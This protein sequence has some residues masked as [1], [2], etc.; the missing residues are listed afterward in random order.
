MTSRRRFATRL[1]WRTAALFAAVVL[2]ALLAVWGRAPVAALLAGLAAVAALVSLWQ[3]VDQGNADLA[4]FV[5]A[6]ARGDLTQSFLRP[7]RGSHFDRV[8]I[9]YERALARLRDERAASA[10]STRFAESL[11]DGAPVALLVLG[12]DDRVTLANQA[13]RRLFRRSGDVPL[14]ALA[15]SGPAFLA[16]LAAV[17]PGSSR[18][19]VLAGGG[20]P[21][22]V[23]LDA[24]LM[25][26]GGIRRRIVAVRVVQPELDRAELDAQV[27]LVRVLT[28]EIM[29]SLT[30]VVS[31][32]ATA[33]RLIA[34]VA[35]D[36]APGI[37]DARLA[38]AAL[39]RRAAELEQFVE[40]YKGFSEAPTLV[41]T[42]IVVD[43]WLGRVIH[44]FRATPHGETARVDIS[45]AP[46]MPA[47]DGDAALLTQVFLNL[48]KNAAEAAPAGD[49]VAIRV[50]AALG[51]DGEITLSVSDGGPGVPAHLRHDV[52][53]PFFTTKRTGT[54]IGLSFARQV[55]L[56][57]GG[58]I[59]IGEQ[60]PS[61]IEIR[62]PPHARDRGA[63]LI[64]KMA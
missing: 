54:G 64:D 10:A 12:E 60:Q 11:A 57:H 55:I 24:T 39:A 25:E 51:S 56:L 37:A 35:P 7:R 26:A 36:L 13:A 58:Q 20:M 40:S 18:L 48:L 53:L 43:E 9:A 29:N 59:G 30:P 17:A 32:A 15:P 38:V 5:G 6:L 34:G 46:E 23:S 47:I 49:G 44:L 41:R 61:R 22:R 42:P 31:L 4:R 62:L 27:D 19:S 28:H 2:T 14:A 63:G 1:V 50:T 33:D 8:G 52:F 16:D 21:Q 45:V 3:L